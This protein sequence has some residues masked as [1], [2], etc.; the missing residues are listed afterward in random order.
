MAEKN[1]LGLYPEGEEPE[2][3]IVV[4]PEGTRIRNMQVVPYGAAKGFSFIIFG[5][6]SDDRPYRW[7]GFEKQ[8]EL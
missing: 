8:W 6:G 3:A 1:A 5:I 4:K 7:N 2:E